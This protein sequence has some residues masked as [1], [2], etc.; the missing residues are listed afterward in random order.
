MVVVD[1]ARG[2][3][4]PA[5]LPERGLVLVSGPCRSGKS[6]WAEHLAASSGKPVVYVATGI[7]DR[8]DPSWAARLE[9]HRCRRPP[10]WTTVEVEGNLT[11]Y[12][13]Q[14]LGAS[15]QPIRNAASP[16]PVL[17]IDSLGTWLAQQ[18]HRDP[19]DWTACSEELVHTLCDPP[20]LVILVVE[21]VGWG[22]VP[23]TAIGGCFRDR[24]GELQQ[25]LMAHASA[26]WLVVAGRALNLLEL[27]LAVPQD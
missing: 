13:K 19:A 10:Q 16:A 2:V 15:A 21:E 27:G 23:P 5:W 18:M 14:W 4:A 8:T 20:G 17:L 3:A 22:V 25:A 9:Q 12:L 24:Q 7:C 1:P 6:R 11:G 26:A